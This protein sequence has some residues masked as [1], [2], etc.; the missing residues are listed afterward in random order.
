MPNDCQIYLTITGER[1]H[2]FEL[3]NSK[4]D[5]PTFYPIPEDVENKQDWCVEHWGC[6]WNRSDF[7]IQKQ[8]LRGLRCSFTTPWTPP[9]GFLHH[10]LKHFPTLWI[11]AEWKEEGGFAGVWIGQTTEEGP[12]VQSMEWQD[13]NLEA[14]FYEFMSE[15]ELEE[16]NRKININQ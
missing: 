5:F 16:H 8:G 13:L 15:E 9:Y 3:A 14:E 6:K 10:I 11:K 4:L 1:S 12:L 2:I 7:Q